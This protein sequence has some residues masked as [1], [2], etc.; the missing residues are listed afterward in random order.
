MNVTIKT[1]AQAAGVS[2]AAVSKALNGYPDIGEETRE[3]IVRISAEM[4]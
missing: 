1:I 3:R 2:P 4:G